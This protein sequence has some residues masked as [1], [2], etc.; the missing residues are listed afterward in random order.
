MNASVTARNHY[1]TMVN[2][3]YSNRYATT[4]IRY[5]NLN[6][7]KQIANAFVSPG[8]VDIT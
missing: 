7:H 3:Q 1:N 6:L 5:P 2:Q 4:C 8:A